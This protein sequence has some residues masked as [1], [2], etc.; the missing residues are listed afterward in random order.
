MKQIDAFIPAAVGKGTRL[1]GESVQKNYSELHEV[2]GVANKAFIE[3]NG[4]A[5]L[6]YIVD[7]LLQ[8]D[9]IKSITIAGQTKESFPVDASK[10]IYYVEGGDSTYDTFLSVLKFYH[11]WETLPELVMNVSADVPLIQPVMID[12]MVHAID[13]EDKRE[14]YWNLILAEDVEKYYPE[15]SKVPFKLREANFRF[16]DLHILD[17]DVVNGREETLEAIMGNRKSVWSNI[18]LVSI[19]GIF[20]YILGRLR[21]DDI[22]VRVEKQFGLHAAMMITEF[23]EPC[24]DLDYA[25]DL[26]N[27]KR[28]LSEKPR[29]VPEGESVAIL[30]NTADLYHYLESRN[31]EKGKIPN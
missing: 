2:T 13:L 17:P 6:R 18:K 16:G 11:T 7:T 24:V 29:V 20:R 30:D 12:R 10:P 9:S 25:K 14:L 22:R 21:A 8:T 1:E 27:F 28:W 26:E 19:S 23:P 5:M 15:V 3:F 31:Y 4:K